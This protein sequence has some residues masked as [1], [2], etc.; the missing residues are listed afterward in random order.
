MKFKDSCM[1]ATG[2]VR[3]WLSDNTDDYFKIKEYKSFFIGEHYYIIE[4]MSD[5]R[6]QTV[7]ENE[8]LVETVLCYI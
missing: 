7:T 2:Q 4:Y 3:R 8:L 1:I 6:K 5:G